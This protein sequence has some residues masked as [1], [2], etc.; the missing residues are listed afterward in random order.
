[1]PEVDIGTVV[2]GPEFYED[3]DDTLES[4]YVG[5]AYIKDHPM[6]QEIT[7]ELKDYPFKGDAIAHWRWNHAME[8]WSLYVY[9]DDDI[10][11]GVE[12]IFGASEVDLPIPEPKKHPR[13]LKIGRFIH[14]HHRK[15][16]L[17]EVLA[18][19]IL[20]A[21]GDREKIV[22]L[23]SDVIEIVPATIEINGED[24]LVVP[25]YEENA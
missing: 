11:H 8:H 18:D 1:M 16:E 20:E 17:I 15:D 10:K 24:Y 12:Y 3:E 4:L 14:M 21:K 9:G 7:A 19:E 6:E 22:K 5:L 25:E 13:P 2:W 23:I